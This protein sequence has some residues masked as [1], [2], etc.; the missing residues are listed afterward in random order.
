M[1]YVDILGA[2]VFKGLQNFDLAKELFEGI[3]SVLRILLIVLSIGFDNLYSADLL[4]FA[5]LTERTLAIV[6]GK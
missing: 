1:Y 5:V 4:S 6:L 2:L 3:I